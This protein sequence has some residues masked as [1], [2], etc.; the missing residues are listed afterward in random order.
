MIRDKPDNCETV[1]A[2][3]PIFLPAAPLSSSRAFSGAL[4]EVNGANSVQ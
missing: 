1:S 2:L 4:S 3:S